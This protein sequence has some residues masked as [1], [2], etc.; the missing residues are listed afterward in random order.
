MFKGVSCDDIQLKNSNVLWLQRSVKDLLRR[1]P[2]NAKLATK[3]N[4]AI[5]GYFQAHK[6]YLIS[7]RKNVGQLAKGWGPNISSFRKCLRVKR[8]HNENYSIHNKDGLLITEPSLI[9]AGQ[10]G[11][12]N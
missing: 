7:L 8:N 11:Q 1:D 9:Y 5:I 6:V 12:G 3:E 4:V 10:L 2:G